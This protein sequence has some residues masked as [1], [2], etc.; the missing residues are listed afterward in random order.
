MT[1]TH[2]NPLSFILRYD[3]NKHLLEDTI[4][5]VNNK[6]LTTVYKDNP[7]SILNST[8]KNSLVIYFGDYFDHQMKD[9]YFAE[10]LYQTKA[11]YNDYFP[12]V[13]DLL[14]ATKQRDAF[15]TIV[16]EYNSLTPEQKNVFVM[17][18]DSDLSDEARLR[19]NAAVDEEEYE[20]I[21][22][23]IESLISK[24]ITEN[25][26]LIA[27]EMELEEWRIEMYK[28]VNSAAEKLRVYKKDFDKTEDLE[29]SWTEEHISKS[30][31]LHEYLRLKEGM[32]V[33]LTKYESDVYWSYIAMILV[34][35]YTYMH[36]HASIFRITMN[37]FNKD[38]VDSL[39]NIGAV[40]AAEKI[41][42]IDSVIDR[43]E[44]IAK[45]ISTVT[46]DKNQKDAAETYFESIDKSI[47]GQ[48]SDELKSIFDSLKTYIMNNNGS[49]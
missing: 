11:L 41:R 21:E 48:L 36:N 24:Y 31:E 29:T 18:T 26:D 16:D 37:L 19:I 5:I 8:V 25:F 34:Q 42:T 12:E 15:N 47:T 3:G 35:H 44:F 20:N 49:A 10:M 23:N 32:N 40:K 28:T 45:V 33:S 30:D 46:T 14:K 38:F 22:P 1:D 9:G 2:L 6:Y 43:E 13:L 27:R 4:E 17:H 39:Q 7:K